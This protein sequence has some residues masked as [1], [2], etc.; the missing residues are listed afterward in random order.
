MMG[1]LSPNDIRAQEGLN[2]I[3]GEAADLYWMQGAMAPIEKLATQETPMQIQ[4]VATGGLEADPE[5]DGVNAE[6]R[7]KQVQ[8]LFESVSRR[9][10]RKEIKACGEMAR[11]YKDDFEKYS[12]WMSDFYEKQASYMVNEFKPVFE[13]ICFKTSFDIPKMAYFHC[14]TMREAAKV[15][16]E[17]KIDDFEAKEADLVSNMVR[18]MQKMA[19]ESLEIGAKSATS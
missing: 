5:E 3:E 1:V 12:E 9:I 17:D 8:P 11:K 7:V 2:R 15:A 10:I 18:E 13:T 19:I 14:F 16:F 4:G 6:A